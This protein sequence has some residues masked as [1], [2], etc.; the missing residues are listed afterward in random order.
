MDGG[1]NPLKDSVQPPVHI[2]IVGQSTD[3][4]KGSWSDVFGLVAVLTSPTTAGCS[5]V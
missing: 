2:N 5:V 3:G 4:P 1:A